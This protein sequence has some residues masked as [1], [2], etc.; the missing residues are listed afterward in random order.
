MKLDN[1]I[2]VDRSC[3]EPSRA[4]QPACA[5]LC[6]AL[7]KVSSVLSQKN[8]LINKS[9]S[10]VFTFQCRPALT[11]FAE[12]GLAPARG[13]EPGNAAVGKQEDL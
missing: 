2:W 13:G 3:R 6:Y 7:V 1:G 10:C 5:R 8:P 9:A 4:K 12:P 11:S